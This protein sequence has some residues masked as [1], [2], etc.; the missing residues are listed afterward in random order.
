MFDRVL[1]ELG[2]SKVN[3]KDK[4]GFT[5]L[6]RVCQEAP[7]QKKTEENEVEEPE[8]C[9][10]DEERSHIVNLLVAK[11]A[12]V[13]CK[14]PQGLQTPLHLAAIN[15]YASVCRFDFDPGQSERSERSPILLGACPVQ[16]GENCQNG[17]ERS[18]PLKYE[19]LYL[20][21]AKRA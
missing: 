21:R 9:K 13:N 2:K 20:G 1:I 17:R 5:P 8:K 4:E 10:N 12:D 6:H 7:P 15:G 18:E 11:G 14:E 3:S 16:L 19:C